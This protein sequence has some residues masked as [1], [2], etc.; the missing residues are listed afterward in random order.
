MS[1]RG[2]AFARVLRLRLLPSPLGHNWLLVGALAWCAHGAWR[3]ERVMD[4]R[5]NRSF[6]CGAHRC[7]V[8]QEVGQEPALLFVERV[9]AVLMRVGVRVGGRLLMLNERKIEAGVVVVVA[10]DGLSHQV[11]DVEAAGVLVADVA[12][13]VAGGVLGG[14]STTIVDFFAKQQLVVVVAVLIDRDV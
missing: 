8:V 13:G 1:E 7:L 9:V 12:V 3:G 5:Q 4:D 14:S 2:A 10:S 11:G 6:L